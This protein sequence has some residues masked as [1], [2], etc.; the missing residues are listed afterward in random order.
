MYRKEGGG[1][2]VPGRGTPGTRGTK[3]LSGEVF[4]EAEG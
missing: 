2:N 3:A 1:R 4:S